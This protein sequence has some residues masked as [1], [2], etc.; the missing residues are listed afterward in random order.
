MK[1]HLG[2]DE[3]FV[4]EAQVLGARVVVDHVAVEAKGHSRGAQSVDLGKLRL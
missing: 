3:V 2:V 4:L 1:T